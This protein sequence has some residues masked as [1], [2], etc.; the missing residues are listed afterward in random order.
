M[1]LLRYGIALSLLWTVG[2]AVQAQDQAQQP[3]DRFKVIFGQ[4]EEGLYLYAAPD[5]GS[6]D[7]RW[8]GRD[9]ALWAFDAYLFDN[10][11]TV[12][13]HLF[14]LKQALPD[15]TA[16]R[17]RFKG[18][19]EADTAFARMFRNAIPDRPVPAIRMDSLL[20]IAAHFFYLHRMGERVT[21]HICTGI[22]QVRKLPQNAGSPYYAAFCFQVIRSSEDPFA[23]LHR[24]KDAIPDSIYKDMPDEA[25]HRAEHGIYDQAAADPELRRLLLDAYAAKKHYLNFKV[26]E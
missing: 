10:Y 19:L 23:I 8:P 11:A 13:R 16:I 7:P 1:S 17:A 15:S 25:L 22:N 4:G 2:H 18:M 6:F 3:A 26:E 12:H 24:A 9:T 5:S 14:E 21:A 20:R